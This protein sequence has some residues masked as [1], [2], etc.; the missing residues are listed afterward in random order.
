[1]GICIGP[2]K[3]RNR[4]FLAPMSGVT[5]EPFRMTASEQGAGLVVSEMVASEELGNAKLVNT[6]ML[7]AI[8]DYL[9][10]PTAVLRE[11]I[12]ES[13][14]AYKPKIA[15]INARAFD[16]GREAGH[17]RALSQRLLTE[18]MG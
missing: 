5:D 3:S 1:M 6:I 8:G 7:G 16:A 12:V 9:P 11:C 17:A 15:D 14:R 4:V 2:I 13:F 10:F 18:P